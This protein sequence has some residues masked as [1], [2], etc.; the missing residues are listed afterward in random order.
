MIR[1]VWQVYLIYQTGV[2]ALVEQLKNILSSFRNNCYQIEQT[3]TNA[4][5]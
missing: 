1:Y 2:I 4:E 5:Y 3:A